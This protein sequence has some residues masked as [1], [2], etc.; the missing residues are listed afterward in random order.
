MQC[1]NSS[2]CRER[3]LMLVCPSLC[4]V[5]CG[6]YF[7]MVNL[8]KLASHVSHHGTSELMSFNSPVKKTTHMMYVLV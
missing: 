6:F 8:T 2:C 5:S 3:R 4:Y 7:Y 1:P